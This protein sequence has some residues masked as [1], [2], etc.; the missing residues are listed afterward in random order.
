MSSNRIRGSP[1]PPSLGTYQECRQL[2]TMCTSTYEAK[3]HDAWHGC[4]TLYSRD[5]AFCSGHDSLAALEHS[6]C[7]IWALQGRGLGFTGLL[8]GGAGPKG[9]V[10][11]R[12]SQSDTAVTR[13]RWVP[14]TALRKVSVVERP[15]KRHGSD[16]AVTRQLGPLRPKSE[17]LHD[18]P[19]PASGS[20][21]VLP[22]W[23]RLRF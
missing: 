23:H 1:I 2:E 21:F 20:G 16:T 22:C 10:R 14:Q 6:S 5:L 11:K 13:L 18:T 4:H 17:S 15:L 8:L 19:M 9:G 7:I 12:G 3:Q